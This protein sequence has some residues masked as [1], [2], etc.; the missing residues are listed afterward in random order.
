MVKVL[1]YIYLQFILIGC[2]CIMFFFQWTTLI[3]LHKNLILLMVL[4]QMLL[5][6]IR[7]V[8]VFPLTHLYT[9]T[10]LHFWPKDMRQIV[11]VLRISWMHILWCIWGVCCPTSLLEQNFHSH[12]WSSPFLTQAFTKAWV[13]VVIHINQFNQGWCIPKFKFLGVTSHFDWRITKNISKLSECSI[14]QHFY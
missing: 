12:F 11:V 10:S 5:L 7:Y 14:H 1:Q 4:K 9:N 13:I 6:P 2:R 8:E 3:A